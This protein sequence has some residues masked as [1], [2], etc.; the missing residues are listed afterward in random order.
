V[1]LLFVVE[2]EK[3][4]ATL[5][6]SHLPGEKRGCSFRL[7]GHLL[8]SRLLA[9]TPGSPRWATT[10]LPRPATR[11]ET[12]ATWVG[13][14]TSTKDATEAVKLDLE[15]PQGVILLG[16]GLHILVVILTQGDL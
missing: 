5:D 8:T 15:R 1:S 14:P 7:A 2:V 12:A 3:T 4:E 10:P 11:G 13:S 9:S 16:Q 6:P